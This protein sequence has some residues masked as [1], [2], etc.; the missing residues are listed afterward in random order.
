MNAPKFKPDDMRQRILDEIERQGRSQADVVEKARLGHGYLTNI[1][2]RGQMP[3]VDKLHALCDELGVSVAWV[4]Y[5][6]EMPAD[7]DRVFDLMQR[8]P[9][10]FYAVLALL[11]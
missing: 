1:L 9:K 2:K 3:S 6:V 11:E 7:F 5:G 4:M 10:K 8:D